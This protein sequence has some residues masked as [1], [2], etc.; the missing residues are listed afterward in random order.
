MYDLDNINIGI[1][2]VVCIFIFILDLYYINSRLY[3]NEINF[4]F[5]VRVISNQKESNN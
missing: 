2:T 5:T 1:S 3:L 4:L